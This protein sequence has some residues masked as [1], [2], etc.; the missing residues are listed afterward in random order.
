M[1]NKFNKILF[2]V[3]A[4]LLPTSVF[5]AASTD[6]EIWIQQSG[7]TFIATIDQFGY[8]NKFGGSVVSDVVASDMLITATTLTMNIDQVGNLN[9]IFGPIILDTSTIDVALTGNSN[10]WDWNIGASS[11]NADDMDMD[12]S[13]TGSSNAMDL[14]IAGS[15]AANNLNFD[16]SQ[17]TGD[18]N[19]YDVDINSANAKWDWTVV[20][21]SNSITTSQLDSTGHTMIVSWTGTSGVANFTQS[22][23][24]CS[25]ITS[26]NGYIDLELNSNNANVTIVQKD[27]G[28]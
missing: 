11:N 19:Q 1:L 5:G 28:D 9:K 15:A 13:I 22:S 7:N 17:S 3:M 27:T 4:I 23:G 26:C 24:T 8:G 12:V 10:S 21:G 2:F 20:G 25:G 18:S 6:N 14:D 16:L